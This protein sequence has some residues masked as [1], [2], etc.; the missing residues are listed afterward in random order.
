MV[1]FSISENTTESINTSH[2]F[3]SI[4]IN[5][6]RCIMT[7]SDENKMRENI[8]EEYDMSEYICDMI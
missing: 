2:T 8:Q 6:N 5:D 4:E 7:Q 3:C 1:S